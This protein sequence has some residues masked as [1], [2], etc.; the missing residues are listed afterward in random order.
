MYRIKAPKGG[1]GYWVPVLANPDIV[2]HYSENVVDTL[3][4]KNLLLLG[5]DRYLTTLM[6]RT[7]P[8][9]KMMFCPQA[10]CKTVVPDTFSVL[11][12][13][14]RRWINSTIHNLFEL[15][16][17][18]D[19]CGVFCFSMRFVS[20]SS[21]PLALASSSLADSFLSLSVFMELA[22]T[23]VLPA[24]SAFTLYLIVVA[25]IPGTV[26]PVLSLILLAIILGIPAVLIVVTSRKVA[27]LG[28]MLIYLMS[29]PIWNFSESSRDSSHS[30]RAD[31]NLST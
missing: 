11:L 22:G 5:E 12:S 10:V 25:I 27:Y 4:K 2:E 3:H 21:F 28:W 14:R 9:R 6:L 18:P 16:L 31:R 29:L 15:F 23:L 7:F 19:L 30:A 1:E 8:R 20:E 24:A 17:V 13:Q 26:K